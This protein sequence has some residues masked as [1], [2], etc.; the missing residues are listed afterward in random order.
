MGRALPDNCIDVADCK[1]CEDQ[2][3]SDSVLLCKFVL[4]V[5]L[6]QLC[7]PVRIA[8]IGSS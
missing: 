6:H 3:D 1:K 2:S 5:A 4:S 7:V 8:K